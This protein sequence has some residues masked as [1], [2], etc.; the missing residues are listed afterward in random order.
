[1]RDSLLNSV[2]TFF[3]LTS[4]LFNVLSLRQRFRKITLFP[5]SKKTNKAELIF[6]RQPLHFTANFNLFGAKELSL[7]MV[8]IC[9]RINGRR[10]DNS[11]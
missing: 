2:L 11:S 6:A 1:M 4:G 9:W 5:L 3:S 10:N 7:C 8:P